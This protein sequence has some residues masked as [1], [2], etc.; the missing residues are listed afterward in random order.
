[1]QAQTYRLMLKRMKVSQKILYFCLPSAYIS[2]TAE[3]TSLS[4]AGVSL[5]YAKV[6]LSLIAFVDCLVVK[7]GI[8]NVSQLQNLRFTQFDPLDC[9]VFLELSLLAK[10]PRLCLSCISTQDSYMAKEII[11]PTK[12]VMWLRKTKPTKPNKKL[13]YPNRSKPLGISY[14]CEL[15]LHA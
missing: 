8:F 5:S 9:L 7:V 3:K 4:Q 6:G 1:M 14:F 10:F 2:L 12:I 15:S 13:N 11:F